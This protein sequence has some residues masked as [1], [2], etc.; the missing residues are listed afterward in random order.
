MH[1]HHFMS[2]G[3]HHKEFDIVH[4]LLKIHLLAMPKNGLVY[5]KC[6][7]PHY[8]GGNQHQK[9][10]GILFWMYTTFSLIFYNNIGD[11]R[12]KVRMFM[13]WRLGMVCI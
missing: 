2:F 1:F 3:M 11:P 13:G 9:D 4:I 6:C 8:K 7:G 12:R 5:G 10:R